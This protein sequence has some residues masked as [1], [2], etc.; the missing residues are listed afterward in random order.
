M[1]IQSNI[2]K[3]QLERFLGDFW[4]FAPIL[5]PF[6]KSHNLSATEIFAIEATYNVV[7]ALSEIPTGYFADVMGRKVSMALSAI[8]R[9][10][11]ILVYIFS[12]SFWGFVFAECCMG[13]AACM[14]SGADSA[15][16][17]DTL[18]ELKREKEHKKFEGTAHFFTNIG[19]SIAGILGSF[20]ATLSMTLPFIGTM[21]VSLIHLPLIFSLQEPKRRISKVKS[22]RDHYIEIVRAIRF[23]LRQKS[24][25]YAGFYSMMIAN[26]N[27]VG[28]WS[29][30]LYYGELGIG[31]AYYGL[32]AAIFWLF[33][34]LGAKLCHNVNKR[35]G[36]KT[37]L[38]LPLLGAP[39]LI[40]IGQVKSVWVLP[41]I[42]FNAAL[43]G[44]SAPL[45]RDVIHR[46]TRSS[47]R[48]TVLS[49]ANMA[50]RFGYMFFAFA[51]GY[52]TDAS[53]IQNG[54]VA[55]GV[56]MLATAVFPV[57]KLIR[58]EARA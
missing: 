54:L 28:V 47:R 44:M 39:S 33:S 23:T 16:L 31:I 36:E 49:V 52:V 56:L 43:W 19:T 15:L 20:L 37:A 9:P 29:Y 25:L 2:W 6:F 40:L 1:G 26:V 38:L 55:L 27:A 8:L 3:L 35:W 32:L 51:V 4:I 12:S 34:G 18:T 21:F 5:V 48:A 41:L 10:L 14:R 13:F 42:A 17:Y 46:N 22:M 11:A 57:I 30:Y 58:A 24:V 7:M 50:R 53:G 45:L